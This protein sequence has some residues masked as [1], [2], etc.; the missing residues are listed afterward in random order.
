MTTTT[1]IKLGQ[2]AILT[3]IFTASDLLLVEASD[4]DFD[5]AKQTFVSPKKTLHRVSTLQGHGRAS[6]DTRF[7]V[8]DGEPLN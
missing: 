1:L 5:N 6:T 7:N 4:R 3:T 8:I 2:V